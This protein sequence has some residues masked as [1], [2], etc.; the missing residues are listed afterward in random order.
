MPDFE[1][2]REDISAEI[3]P[4][5]SAEHADVFKSE[6]HRNFSLIFV[7]I[8]G[9][10]VIALSVWQFKKIIILEKPY[11]GDGE[12]QKTV[13]G[14][15]EESAFELDKEQLKLQ[16]T[17]AD[18][19]NDYEELYFYQTSP[20]LAD[21]DSD[22]YDDPTE[23]K[24]GNDPNCPKGEN[25]FSLKEPT[26]DDFDFGVG[27]TS[28]ELLD[29]SSGAQ[30]DAAQVSAEQVRQIL[31]QQGHFTTQELANIDDATLMQIYNQSVAQDQGTATAVT[32]QQAIEEIANKT[33]AE[34]R[35]ALMQ[36]GLSEDLVNSVDD[37][38][39]KEMY[40][41]AISEATLNFE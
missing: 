27:S 36:Q 14:F 25:C 37:A 19:L 29:T 23:L 40:A 32:K 22:G 17:D 3:P 15:T 34:I 35:S 39:L 13:Q 26:F 8:I 38:T 9:I 4:T 18:G 16:D 1:E 5:D 41:D 12:T 6:R 24:S 10:A 11:K 28:T 33:P 2:Q 20:Y 21:S 31:V 30:F 7:C